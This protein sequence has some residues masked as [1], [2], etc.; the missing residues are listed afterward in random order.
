MTPCRELPTWTETSKPGM[1]L[2][3]DLG[4]EKVGAGPH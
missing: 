4:S 3:L 1:V 2:P